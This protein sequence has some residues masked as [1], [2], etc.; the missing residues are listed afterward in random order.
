MQWLKTFQVPSP[1]VVNAFH[2]GKA[3]T[4]RA[5]ELQVAHNFS[6]RAIPSHFT[7]PA[8]PAGTYQS[9]AR[10]GTERSGVERSKRRDE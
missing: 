4:L 5:C 8:C 2:E 3:A 9:R 1:P 10:S 6:I 7:P